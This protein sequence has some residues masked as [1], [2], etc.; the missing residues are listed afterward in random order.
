M[1]ESLRLNECRGGQVNNQVGIMHV[2]GVRGMVILLAIKFAS[3]TI[4]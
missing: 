3:G 4:H 1:I 2:L